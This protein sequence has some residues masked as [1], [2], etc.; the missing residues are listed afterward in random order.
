[1]VL[2]AFAFAVQ[3]PS[4]TDGLHPDPVPHYRHYEALPR[5]RARKLEH[6]KEKG[7]G[8]LSKNLN[9]VVEDLEGKLKNVCLKNCFGIEVKKE[10]PITAKRNKQ[11]KTRA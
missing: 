2:V 4:F 11:K 7:W 8:E 9:R 3:L 1:M 5:T 10:K 6:D